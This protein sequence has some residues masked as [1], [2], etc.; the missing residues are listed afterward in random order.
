MADQSQ[1]KKKY[2]SV[3]IKAGVSIAFFMVLLSYIQTNE[4]LLYIQ[5][6]NWFYFGLSLLL[7]PLLLIVSCWKWKVILDI[8]ERKISFFTL[9]KIYFIGYFFSNLLPST[10]GGDVARSIYAGRLIG[11]HSFTAV[12]VFL[13]RVTGLFLLIVLVMVAPLMQP[14]L[15]T[16]PFVYLPACGA[17]FILLV[18]FWLWKVKE[19]LVLPGKIMDFVFSTL[20]SLSSRV[21]SSFLQRGVALLERLSKAIF[22]R[23]ITFHAEL[24][25]A[26][27]TIRR[28][29]QLFST[30]ALLTVLFYFLTWLNVYVAF[31]AFGI[32]RG[33]W[34]IS[35]LVPTIMFVGQ[36]PVT[37]LGNLGFFESVYVFYYLLLGIPA[38]GSLA[39]GLLMRLKLLGLGVTGFL[40]YLSYKNNNGAKGKQ[41]DSLRETV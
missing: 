11:D 17:F 19:P 3:L 6:V 31:R 7:G 13:E 22:K 26:L 30:I 36:L 39:M 14:A 25:M 24:E 18:F 23:L 12:S 38:E 1:N 5:H 34:E 8:Q 35:A 16:N 2:L 21:R 15:Y 10:M 20:Y 41:V 4:L 40:I 29:R 28:N 27:A 9:I 33:L 32:Q 37:L